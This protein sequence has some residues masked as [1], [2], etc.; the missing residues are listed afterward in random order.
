MGAISGIDPFLMN[1]DGKAWI[2]APTGL[3]D[4]PLP[5]HYEPQESVIRNP[6]YGQ[7]CNPTRME[8]SRA[9]NPYHRAWD[10]PE[11]PYVLTTYRLT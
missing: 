3:E 8:W 11:F 4:G 6:L 2:F 10:D 1:T 5:A 7:Q 9:E